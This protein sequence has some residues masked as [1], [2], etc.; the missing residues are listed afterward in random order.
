MVVTPFY[1][2]TFAHMV[3]YVQTVTPFRSQWCVAA[4]ETTSPLALPS[5]TD[6]SSPSFPAV[7]VQPLGHCLLPRGSL[8][9]GSR[10]GDHFCPQISHWNQMLLEL[11][12]FTCF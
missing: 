5:A 1:G 11:R 6:F 12:S 9:P 4:S 10:L 7:A 2:A 3:N 8:P